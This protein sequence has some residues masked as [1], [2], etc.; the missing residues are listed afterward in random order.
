MYSVKK[1]KDR[2]EVHEK[3]RTYHRE[4]GDLASMIG[5]SQS[6]L[7]EALHPNTGRAKEQVDAFLQQTV[8]LFLKHL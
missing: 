4:G 8:T 2:Q 5:L 1:G 7:E 3:L 6:E